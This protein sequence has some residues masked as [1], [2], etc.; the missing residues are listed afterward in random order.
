MKLEFQLINSPWQ[1]PGIYVETGDLG[2]AWMLDCGDLS[3]LEVRDLIRVKHVFVSHTHIDHF[4]GFDWIVRMNLAHDTQIY[5]YGPEGITQAID[6]K[7]HSY[8]W[9]STDDSSYSITAVEILPER[10][11]QT[12]FG[13]NHRFAISST[14]DRDNTGSL[15]LPG[16]ATVYFAPLVHKAPCLCYGLEEPARTKVNALAMAELHLQSGPWV[17]QLKR[18]LVAGQPDAELSIGAQTFRAG[19]LGDKLLTQSPP[20]RLLYVTDS[21]FNKQ[22]VASIRSIASNTDELWCE[23]CYLHA[24][25]DKARQNLH[26]TARQAG[27]LAQEIGANK[28]YLFHQSRRYERNN[29]MHMQEACETFPNTCDPIVFG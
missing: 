13:C 25:L 24:H 3:R 15:P 28:L 19:E 17:S 4:V 22:S 12:T 26:F 7:L 20:R 6:N 11:K 14:S 21:I 18:F 23:A 1:D 9:N 5:V 8:A 29:K 16:G 10:I 27:R 2:Q